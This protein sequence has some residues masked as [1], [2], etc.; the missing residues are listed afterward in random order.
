MIVLISTASYDVKI[1][2]LVTRKRVTGSKFDK[3]QIRSVNLILSDLKI[4]V[5]RSRSISKI[6]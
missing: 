4:E 5:D 6:R 3:D 2:D 1:P